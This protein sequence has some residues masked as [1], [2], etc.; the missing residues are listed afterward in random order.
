MKKILI[1]LAVLFFFCCFYYSANAYVRLP[2]IFSDNMVM[3]Q[4]EKIHFHGFSEPG[5]R[6]KVIVSWDS[7]TLKTVTGYDANWSVELQTPKAG[8]PYEITVIGDKTITIH[9]ILIGEVWLCSGQS[10]M[11]FNADWG[12]NNHQR[13]SQKCLS[14]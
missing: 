4:N 1:F 10:N 9:N 5:Q 12:Y 2:D 14:S 11:E 7:D 3:Q 8:G 6:I 13:R